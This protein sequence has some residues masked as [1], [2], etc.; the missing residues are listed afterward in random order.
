MS[1]VDVH[2]L[3]LET[4]QGVL[5]TEAF[6]WDQNEQT[7]AWSKRFF[8][9]AA[10][11]FEVNASWGMTKTKRRGSSPPSTRS[12]YSRPSLV[13]WKPMYRTAAGRT[14]STFT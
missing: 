10:G 12:V 3:G 5:L 2:A 7:R 11:A 8:T 6:Y 9:T 1:I 4:A 13:D 14:A